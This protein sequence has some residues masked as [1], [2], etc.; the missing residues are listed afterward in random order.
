M[1]ISEILKNAFNP[2]FEAPIEAWEHFALAGDLIS[3]E[4]EVI[5]KENNTTEKFLYFILRIL[6]W[7]CV[8]SHLCNICK[9]HQ[10]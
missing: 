3:I 1:K 2:Y 7:R 10:R 5:L 8:T 4:K 9:K 6:H